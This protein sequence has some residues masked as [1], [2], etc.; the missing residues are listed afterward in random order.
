VARANVAAAVGTLAHDVYNVGSGTEVSVLELLETLAELL[1][2][3]PVATAPEFGP[4]RPGE[5]LRSCLDVRRAGADLE[6]PAPTPL[7]TGLA[8]TVAWIRTLTSA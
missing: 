1:D 8:A 3:D 5:V 2:A 4:A 7:R 6:L